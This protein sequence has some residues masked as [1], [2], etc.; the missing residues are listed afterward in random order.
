M[1]CEG[2]EVSRGVHENRF[3]IAHLADDPK[4]AKNEGDIHAEHNLDESLRKGHHSVRVGV[5]LHRL[6]DEVEVQSLLGGSS[7]ARV[8]ERSVE[9]SVEAVG[10]GLCEKGSASSRQRGQSHSPA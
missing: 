10:D 2:E 6:E 5:L 3:K 8:E 4:R 7:Q 1:S 9:S